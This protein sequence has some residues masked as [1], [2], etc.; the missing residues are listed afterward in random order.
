MGTMATKL[1]KTISDKLE[2]RPGI[3]RALGNVGWLFWDRLLRM[4]LGLVVSALMTRMLGPSRYG[5]LQW[6]SAWAAYFSL[7]AGLGLD[8]IVV[9]DI[10]RFP[11]SKNG[12]L[13]TTFAMK[14]AGSFAAFI[15]GVGSIVIF[16][17]HVGTNENY[18]EI[19]VALYTGISIMQAF[20]TIDFWYQSQVASQYVVYVRSSSFLI[21]SGVRLWLIHVHASVAA[22]AATMLIEATLSAIGLYVSYRLNRHAIREWKFEARWMKSLLRDSWPMIVTAFAVTSQTRVDQLLLG[23]MVGRAAVGQFSAAVGMIEAFGFLPMV[24][25][26][27]VL[28]NII[29]ARSSGEELFYLRMCNLYRLMFLM[30]LGV[31][32]PLVF[33]AKP[34]VLFMLGNKYLAASH[35]LVLLGI[36]VFFMNFGVARSVF[37]TTENLLGYKLVAAVLG[38]VINVALNWL[39]IPHYQAVGSI[40]AMIISLFVTTFLI[41]MFYKP[42][43]RNFIEMIRAIITPW[44]ISLH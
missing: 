13:G 6:A 43:R 3:R 39:L 44:R 42:V 25:Y 16:R 9:R 30:F 24:I 17:P 4:G 20:D 28:P 10:V 19:L 2:N 12:I 36:R 11:E 37:L 1:Q 26:T 31:A 14:L 21:M 34:I 35:L 23:V 8:N 29:K 33:V 5:L 27:A 38:G 22:F 32:I 41:D 15:L 40:W 7:I 18:L